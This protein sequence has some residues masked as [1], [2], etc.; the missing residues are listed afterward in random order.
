MTKKGKTKEKRR[1][2]RNTKEQ[3]QAIDL[4]QQIRR[5]ETKMEQYRNRHLY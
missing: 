4:H 2:A 5:V 1:G 3:S